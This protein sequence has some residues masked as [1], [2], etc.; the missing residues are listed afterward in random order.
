VKTLTATREGAADI[1]ARLRAELGLPRVATEAD[2]VG[3]GVF[4][5][6]ETVVT[7]EAVEALEQDGA[8]EVLVPPELEARLMLLERAALREQGVAVSIDERAKEK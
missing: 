5:P 6:V 3:N 2:R 8:I 7:V 4:A 1:Q